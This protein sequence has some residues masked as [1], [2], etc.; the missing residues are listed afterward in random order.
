MVFD[1]KKMN[2]GL[3]KRMNIKTLFIYFRNQ[4]NY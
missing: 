4:F 3:I 2:E 1:R